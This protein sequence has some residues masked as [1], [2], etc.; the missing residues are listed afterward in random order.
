MAIAIVVAALL[1]TSDIEIPFAVE[2]IY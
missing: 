2:L 1:V